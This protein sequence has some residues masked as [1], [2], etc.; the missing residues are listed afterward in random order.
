MMFAASIE[1]ESY[2]RNITTGDN[3]EK[4]MFFRRATEEPQVSP[5]LINSIKQNNLCFQSLH[6]NIIALGSLTVLSFS[7]QNIV[8]SWENLNN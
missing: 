7:H 2:Y 5:Y 6:Y 8:M 3:K 1:I 4:L